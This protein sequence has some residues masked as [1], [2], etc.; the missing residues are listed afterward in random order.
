MIMN[1]AQHDVAQIMIH[2]NSE[3]I[4]SE[5]SKHYVAMGWLTE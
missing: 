4:L 2:Q 3:I 1:A 5:L